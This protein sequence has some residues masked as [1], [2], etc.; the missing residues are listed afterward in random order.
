MVPA[1]FPAGSW[2]HAPDHP[3]TVTTYGPL[4]R[5]SKEKEL[6]AL[7]VNTRYWY[8]RAYCMPIA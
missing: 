8:L 2:H 6:F 5:L 4:E 1:T 7:I 3:H